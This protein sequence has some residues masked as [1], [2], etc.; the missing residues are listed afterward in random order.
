MEVGVELSGGTMG[1]KE[2]GRRFARQYRY[3]GGTAM[4]VVAM[5]TLAVETQLCQDP[6]EA[7]TPP[8]GYKLSVT[9]ATAVSCGTRHQKRLAIIRTRTSRGLPV[10]SPD[11]RILTYIVQRYGIRDNLFVLFHANS[12]RRFRLSHSDSGVFYL[13][14]WAP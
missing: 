11:R 5:R 4:I 1:K 9:A 10:E 3:G 12:G 8:P 6:F 13:Q 2:Y 7:A 14:T